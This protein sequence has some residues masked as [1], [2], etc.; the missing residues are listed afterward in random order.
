MALEVCF[1]DS[2][3]AVNLNQSTLWKQASELGFKEV[4]AELVPESV[5]ATVFEL[6][7]IYV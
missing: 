5:T 2:N 6:T 1:N 3:V 7:D 4:G